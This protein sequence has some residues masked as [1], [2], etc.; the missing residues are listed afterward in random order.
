MN[1]NIFRNE[2]PLGENEC[3][4]DLSSCLP[5]L[6]DVYVQQ[7]VMECLLHTAVSVRRVVALKE[8]KTIK[9]LNVGNHSMPRVRG[10]HSRATWL[11]L[12]KSRQASRESNI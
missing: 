1:T 6:V 2:F 5:S 4:R 11:L 12:G 7:V 8:T 9:G 10:A 3:K